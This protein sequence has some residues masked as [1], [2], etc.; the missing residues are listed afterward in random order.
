MHLL[1][2]ISQGLG[3]CIQGT[4]LLRALW[5]MGHDVDLYVNSPIADKLNPLWSDWEILGRIFTHHDQINIKDYDFGVSAY[6]RRQ[7]V[8]MFPPGLCLKVEKRHVKHQS[9]SE[10]NVELARWLG[11]AG[12]L[13]EA[14]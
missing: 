7:L 5:L 8:R 3:N 11:Y 10:A 9:E 12:R 14:A 2:E 1:V 4:P 6:G 13:R